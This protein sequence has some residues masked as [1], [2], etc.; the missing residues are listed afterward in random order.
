MVTVHH[1]NRLFAAFHHRALEPPPHACRAARFL[2]SPAVEPGSTWIWKSDGTRMGK[3]RK[4][5]GKPTGKPTG[6]PEFPVEKTSTIG[7]CFTS[8][9]S[10]CYFVIHCGK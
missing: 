1:M 7:G 9:Y 6:K 2:V 5:C 8:I 3:H 4:R 10:K